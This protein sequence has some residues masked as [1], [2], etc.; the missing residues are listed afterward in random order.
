VMCLQALEELDR[1]MAE[2]QDQAGLRR[3][4]RSEDDGF[5]RSD[6]FDSVGAAAGA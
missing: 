6:A 5:E 4:Q 2:Y 3:L 1:Q